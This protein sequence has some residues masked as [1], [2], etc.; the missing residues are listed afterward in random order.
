MWSQNL[1]QMI[2]IRLSQKFLQLIL[3]HTVSYSISKILH[4]F[5]KVIERESFQKSTGRWEMQTV[6]YESPSP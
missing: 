6:G 5:R 2:K 1:R 3:D 4:S